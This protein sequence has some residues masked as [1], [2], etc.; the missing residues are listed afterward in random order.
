MIILLTEK[1]SMIMASA[2]TTAISLTITI[3]IRLT[4][5]R[6]W[7]RHE[8]SK[9]KADKAGKPKACSANFSRCRV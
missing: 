3:T 4:I 8:A 2:A 9:G 1:S 7:A 6:L 5:P